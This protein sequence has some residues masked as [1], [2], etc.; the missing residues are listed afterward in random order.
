MR[1]FTFLSLPLWLLPALVCAQSIT[2]SGQVMDAQ[3]GEPLPGASIVVANTT[4]GT[5]TDQHG[6]YSLQ[7]T[8]PV[9]AENIKIKASYVGYQT[10]TK[11]A[12]AGENSTLDFLLK[13]S[14][15]LEEVV[16]KSIRADERA[17]VTQVTVEREEIEKLYVGQDALYVLEK[18]T[19]SILTYS[20]SGTKLTNY[21]KMRLRGIDQKRINITLNGVPLNDMIDQGVY[22]SNFTDF[23]NSVES[24]QVQRGVG[25]ST[26]GTAS[27]AGSINFESVNLQDAKPSAELQLTGGSFNTFR[28]SG[29]VKTGLIND[30]FSFY[31]RFSKTYS[32]GYREHSGTDSYSFFFSGGYFGEKDL[33]KLTGFTGRTKNGLAY[34]PVALPDIKQ[35]PRTNYVSENDIDNFGQSLVQLQHTHLFTDYTSLTSTLYYGSAGG[36][37]PYGYIAESTFSQINY[38]LYNDHYGFMSYLS[39]STLENRLT[40]DG[41]VHL[42][43]FRR[44][45]IEYIIPNRITPYYEDRAQKD[46]VSAFGKVSY[47]LDNLLLFGDVQVRSVWLGL[48]PDLAF[49]GQQAAVPVRQWTFINPKVGVTY[50][51]SE[52]IDAYASYGRSGREPTRS[53]ILGSSTI[54]ADNLPMVRNT[55]SIKPEY[56]NDLEAGVRIHQEKLSVQANLFYMQFENEITAIGQSVQGFITL[57]ENVS[58]SYRR[59]VETN[60]NYQP[61]RYFGFSGDLTYMQSRVRAYTPAGSDQTYTDVHPVISPNWLINASATYYGSGWQLSVSPRYVSKSYLELTNQPNLTMPD[62]F[63][64]DAHA[65]VSLWQR[66]TLSLHVNNI[67]N[68]EYFT[69]GEPVEYN[70]QRVPGYF[71]QPPANFYMM[72]D[73]KF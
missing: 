37:F 66:H 70:K 40:I 24:V 64:L 59:G 8:S 65:N 34:L 58:S 56:V 57:T 2:M 31:S 9:S 53:D 23:G 49:L 54:N 3:T 46:E 18:T 13:P 33:V 55:N 73:I 42:Y 17:P 39:Y 50:Q 35:N 20:E 12:P 60:W 1:I 6:H 25:T 32:E 52:D 10:Q 27:Y 43:T 47:E 29:E 14:T 41:G 69:G 5:V 36:D 61:V 26:N 21:G 11:V 48:T 30:K 4:Q 68:Q 63:V 7:I 67:F 72:L 38:P 51:F 22:F 15:A 62:F 19:P 71:V 28:G 44:K 16:I 45:D